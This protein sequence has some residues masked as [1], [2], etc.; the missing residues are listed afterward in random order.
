MKKVISLVITLSMVCL[1]LS[2]CKPQT[3]LVKFDANGGE[4]RGLAIQEV[5]AGHSA[6]APTV[7]REGYE[8]DGWDR[9]FDKV[10]QNM[11]V[12]AQ[13]T[14]L[15]TVSFD[16]GDCGFTLSSVLTQTIR[17]G[18]TPQVPE[19]TPISGYVFTGWDKEIEEATEDT[20]YTAQYIERE[21]TA[22]EIYDMLDESVV[23]ITIYDKD[24]YSFALGSGFF[25]DEEGTMVTNYHVLEGAYSADA[26]FYNGDVYPIDLVYGFS[27]E[28]DLALIHVDVP[29]SVPIKIADRDV[30]TGETVYALG[31]SEGLTGTFSEGI[32]STTTRWVDGKDCI[33]ITAPISH[34]N[35]G[36]PCVNRFC[37]VIGI[38]SMIY[39]EGQ[40]LNFAIKIHEIDKLGKDDPLTLEEIYVLMGFD[41]MEYTYASV[42]GGEGN[43]T[44]IDDG[45]EA[46]AV[47]NDADYVEWEDNSSLEYADILE[48]FYWTAGCLEYETDDLDIFVFSV[49]ESGQN[50]YFYILP[51]WL[52][53][54]EFIFA[55][56]AIQDASGNIVEASV[57]EFEL[58][59]IDNSG[60]Y[61]YLE[62]PNIPVGDYYVILGIEEG[63][64]YESNIYYEISADYGDY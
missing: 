41:E 3:Y 20:T 53:D 34:G 56:L 9:A 57:S 42:Y 16:L 1:L 8:F 51:Y 60:N 5:E 31:S 6:K 17:E 46:V 64:P 54:T 27:V 33:Q 44:L 14:K 43:Y 13:W 37:E 38:N 26:T 36:G 10:D 23:E 59:T 58:I 62:Y 12:M 32:V 15:V 21:Y 19:V 45:T 55:A 47:Y 40:N 63:F 29:H 11:T 39:L 48:N 25:I 4:T 61:L 7:T 22:E 18:E 30:V 49:T 52:E 28:R 2:A 50:A 24:G 35:S